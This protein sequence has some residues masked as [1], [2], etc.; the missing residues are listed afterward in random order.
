MSTLQT[1]EAKIKIAEI[2]GEKVDNK[3]K[4]QLIKQEE[5]AIKKERKDLEAEEL[6]QEKE[7]VSWTSLHC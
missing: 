5:A 2:S 3:A 7:K 4:L 6:Q 1:E